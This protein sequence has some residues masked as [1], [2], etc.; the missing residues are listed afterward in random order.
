M[1]AQLTS[2]WGFPQSGN[3]RKIVE[4]RTNRSYRDGSQPD[5]RLPRTIEVLFSRNAV[6]IMEAPGWSPP[7]SRGSLSIVATQC[8]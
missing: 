4:L 7:R 1:R 8:L 5:S 3:S 6:L 2:E